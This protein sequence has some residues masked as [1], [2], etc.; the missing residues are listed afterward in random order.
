MKTIKLLIMIVCVSIFLTLPVFA[1][2]DGESTPTTDTPVVED[3]LS[4]GVDEPSEEVTLPESMTEEDIEGYWNEFK[5][6]IA[7]ISVWLTGIF[8]VS[9]VAVVGFIAKWA[10]TKI[11][12]KIAEDASKTE[13]K[14]DDKLVEN[15][16]AIEGLVNNKIDTLAIELTKLEEATKTTIENQEKIDA[17]LTLFFTNVK[18]SA[19][20]KAELL[21]I[22]TGIKKYEGDLAGIVAEA[23]KAIDKTH[24]EQV[25]LAE[26]TPELDRLIEETSYMKLG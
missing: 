9:G 18:I 1:L 13:T 26:P 19:S 10:F 25:S 22:A 5:E 21:A 7:N 14:I 23:Q 11:F 20:V 3:E 6:T 24:E 8:G 17:L 16:A 2:E 4:T 15:R 12:D